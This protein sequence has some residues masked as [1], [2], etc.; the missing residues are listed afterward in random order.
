VSRSRFCTAG[1]VIIGAT[2]TAGCGPG[3]PPVVPVSGTVTVDGKPLA[4]GAIMVA[5]EKGRAAGGR[6]GPDGRF[7]LS[8][9]LPGDGVAAGTHRVEVIATKPLPGNRRQWLVPKKVRSLATSPLRLEVTGPTTAAVIAI[10]TGG[11]TL[12]IES[13]D[14]GTVDEGLYL[15]SP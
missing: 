13:L 9:W 4:S 8:S 10:E 6:I 3:R 14:G 2:L 11:E 7:E 15:S 1:L 12:E 5:P